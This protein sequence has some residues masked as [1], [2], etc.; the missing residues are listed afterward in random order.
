MH[1]TSFDPYTTGALRTLVAMVWRLLEVGA[2]AWM[3]MS[4]DT[5][6]MLE[7]SFPTSPPTVLDVAGENLPLAGYF[8][9][10]FTIVSS[11][12]VL[13][14]FLVS[15]LLLAVRPWGALSYV[16]CRCRQVIMSFSILLSC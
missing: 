2:K 3:T 6:T 14:G 12:E 16:V 8:V 15:W 9:G 11:L 10:A 4:A 5:V 1:R 13:L 7:A